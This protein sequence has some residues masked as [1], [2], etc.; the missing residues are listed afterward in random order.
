MESPRTRGVVRRIRVVTETYDED[1]DDS[2]WLV[3]SERYRDS[4]G[5]ADRRA[6]AEFAE[7]SDSEIVGFD[8][9]DESGTRR[10]G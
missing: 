1:G 4:R 8:W 6:T 7:P 5:C 3:G 9:M 10:R 2:H